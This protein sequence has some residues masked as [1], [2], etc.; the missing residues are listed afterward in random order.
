MQPI[1]ENEIE[2][3]AGV[4]MAIQF[5]RLQYV[6]RSI[7]QS[8]CHKAAYN[9][10]LSIHDERL[11]KTFSYDDKTDSA[12]HVI[13][14]PEGASESYRDPEI[15]WNAA[16]AAEGRWDSQVGK[17]MVLALPDDPQITLQDRI[18]LTRDFV[19]KNFV[20]HGLICQIDIH[21]PEKGES[22]NAN[23]HAHV[24]M[25][26]RPCQGEVFGKKARHLDVAVRGGYVVDT[27]KQWGRLWAQ[28]QNGYFKE[29]GIELQVDPIGLVPNIHL[30]PV[31]MRGDRAPGVMQR[32]M[33]LQE[34]NRRY[35]QQE[36]LV[37]RYLTQEQATFTKEAVNS[38]VQKHI[39]Q[40]A[41]AD[42]LQRFFESDQLILV[43]QDRYTSRAVL[44]EE[45]KLLRMADRLTHRTVEAPFSTAQEMC[46]RVRSIEISQDLTEAQQRAYDHVLSGSNLTLVSGIAG[47]GKSHVIGALKDSYEQAGYTVRGFAAQANAVTQMKQNGFSYANNV[48]RFLFKQYYEREGRSFVADESVWINP[49][50]EVWL[51]DT[52]TTVSNPDIA[53]LLDLAWVSNVKVVLC[54]DEQQ[55]PCHARGGVFAALKRRYGS[56]LLDDH[57][58]QH[59][60]AQRQM[61]TAMAT[62]K[63]DEALDQMQALGVWHHHYKESAM[64]EDLL[65]RWY[66]CYQKAP[67]NSFVILDQRH[68]YVRV[69]NEKIHDVLKSRGD[70]G[71]DEVAV[72][73]AKHGLMRF[74]AGDSI[75]FMQDDKDLDVSSGLRGRLVQ[76][77]GDCF[78]VRVDGRADIVFDPQSYNN[79]QHGYAGQVHSVQGQ[80]FDHVFVAH[81][82][83]MDSEAFYVA[84][85]RHVLSCDYFSSGDQAVV[86]EQ[87]SL[88]VPKQGM[89]CE[90]D[91]HNSGGYLDDCVAIIC[92][93]F[94][95]DHD[96][97]RHNDFSRAPT[98]LRDDLQ[99]EMYLG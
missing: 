42:F 67:E 17:E 39:E 69:F 12:Y 87:L 5:A 90:N 76:A 86:R 92:D 56:A 36:D 63:M 32:S 8:V 98:Y 54:G 51:V 77:E 73:T 26:T 24:L 41:Q 18:V 25:P 15:L 40:A 33:M 68:H 59:D 66:A 82:K 95:K 31:R 34:E 19:Q 1:W 57:S 47:S 11:E 80:T 27:D 64:V 78:T 16:E 89:V 14:L 50:K 13:L 2:G 62:G 28:Q 58:R 55:S 61:L 38:F 21:G 60:D 49:G 96:Y 91:K 94:Y 93:V 46:E 99:K 88:S 9:G 45:R 65:S 3:E 48:R 84:C 37:L 97:Y 72:E 85:S 23:W 79:F 29:R 70:V 22:E 30:G 43:G 53:E 74:S 75:V 81:S 7:G 6:K 20:K 44:D 52:A 35:A 71:M 10:R 4:L 83:A